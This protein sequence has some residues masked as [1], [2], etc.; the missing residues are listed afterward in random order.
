MSLKSTLESTKARLNALLTYANETTGKSD[1]SIGDAIQT[2]CAGYGGEGGT[3]KLELIGTWTGYL[4]ELT[5][6]AKESVDTNILINNQLQKYPIILSTISCDGVLDASSDKNWNGLT[7]NLGG[8]VI[9]GRYHHAAS[10]WYPGVPILK[11]T[12]ASLEEASTKYDNGYGVYACHNKANYFQF[13]R[14]SHATNCPKIMGGNYTVNV[15]GIVG[16]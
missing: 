15:Y 10:I 14:I 5:D 9:G 3:L 2:L 11:Y 8:R 1:T 16:I 4:P 6:G 7:V 12:T 13:Y